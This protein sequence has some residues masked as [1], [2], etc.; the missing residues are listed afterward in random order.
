AP[1]LFPD[2][3]RRVVSAGVPARSAGRTDVSPAGGHQDSRDHFF[4]HSRDYGRAGSDGSADPRPPAP[5]GRSESGL[6]I[7]PGV[8]SAGDQM[9]PPASMVNDHRQSDLS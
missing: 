4:L 7:L 2:H 6:A 3:H 5:P 1:F 9:V 8:V